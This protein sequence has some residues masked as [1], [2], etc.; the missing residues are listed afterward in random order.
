[1]SDYAMGHSAAET[2]RLRLQARLYAEPT[3]ALLLQ[4]GIAPG[5]RVLDVGSGA[6]DVVLELARIVGTDGAVAG[7]DADPDVVAVARSRG[8][9]VSVGTSEEPGVPGPFDAVTGRLILMHVAD[10]VAVVRGLARLVRPGGI[11]TFQDFAISRA[12][13]VP[14]TP[15]YAQVRDWVAAG[16]AAA[17]ARPD[18]GHELPGILGRAGLRDVRVAAATPATADPAGLPLE[19]AAATVGSLAQLLVGRGLAAA[20]E[21]DD[22]G[23]RLRA[24][25]AEAGSL[26]FSPELV[27]A[28]G[29]VGQGA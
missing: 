24:E 3:R 12:H 18:A 23:P 25:C 19:H 6:G 9:S 8:A 15:L 26:V 13:S 5:M 1:V 14:P 16:L 4:A 22:L 11:V 17:G 10:P 7:I 21:L 29:R 20:D 28:W 27:A 2:E